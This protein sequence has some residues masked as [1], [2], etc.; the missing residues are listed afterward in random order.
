MKS[1]LED[2]AIRKAI[3]AY[4]RYLDHF[5]GEFERIANRDYLEVCRV[6]FRHRTPHQHAVHHVAGQIVGH[7][8]PNGVPPMPAYAPRN[9]KEA[10]VMG[11]SDK[12]V[13]RYHLENLT[14]SETA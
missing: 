1:H 3:A 11:M 13:D 6:A 9:A 7:R 12:N 10:P 2:P 4:A 5:G 8:Y 14:P